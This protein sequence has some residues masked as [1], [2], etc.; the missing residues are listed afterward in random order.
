MSPASPAMRVKHLNS[1]TFQE[2]VLIISEVQPLAAT[3]AVTILMWPLV[4][5]LVK[6][7]TETATTT[8]AQGASRGNWLLREKYAVKACRSSTVITSEPGT[9]A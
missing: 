9:K 5:T 2:A 3:S 6:T 8:A 4:D 1:E 7:R